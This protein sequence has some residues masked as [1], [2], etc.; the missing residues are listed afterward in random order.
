MDSAKRAAAMAR[1]LRKR[2]ARC[3]RRV[4]SARISIALV[5]IYMNFL[6][7]RI[8]VSNVHD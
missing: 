7:N 8:C 2:S 6:F 1:S 3:C 4:F 5:L